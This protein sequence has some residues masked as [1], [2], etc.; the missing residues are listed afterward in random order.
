VLVGNVLFNLISFIINAAVLLFLIRWFY[1]VSW[2]K[3]GLTLVIVIVLS[4]VVSFIIG[5]LLGYIR[6]L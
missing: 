3:S 2:K 5:I 6:G 1:K 4:F